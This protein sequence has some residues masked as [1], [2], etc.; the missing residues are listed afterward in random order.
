MIGGD[1]RQLSRSHKG[2]ITW[3]E[4]KYHPFPL[5]I[6]QFNVRKPVAHVCGRFEIGSGF[7]NLGFHGVTP[8]RAS[9]DRPRRLV[10][11][12]CRYRSRS[13]CYTAFVLL[14]QNESSCQLSLQCLPGASS[15]PRR[16]YI[17]Y[18]SMAIMSGSSSCKG[19][20][21][22]GFIKHQL[23]MSRSATTLP[24]CCWNLG[25]VSGWYWPHSDGTERTPLRWFPVPR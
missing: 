10:L 15:T 14:G 19:A 1:R 2:K 8:F 18:A 9:G 7:A 17:T 4:T 11:G 12:R 20:P 23:I 3:V 25:Y 13:G 22:S 16:S 24:S 6:R 21:S 5:V